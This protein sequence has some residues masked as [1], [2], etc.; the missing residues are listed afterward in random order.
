M[1]MLNRIKGLEKYEVYHISG[2]KLLEGNSDV[3]GIENFVR[4]RIY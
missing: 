2:Q 3:I 4:E 1:I